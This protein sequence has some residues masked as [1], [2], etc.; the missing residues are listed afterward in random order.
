MLKPFGPDIWMADGT[1]VTGALGFLYPTRMAVIR[2]S[3]GALFVW[4]PTAP[5]DRLRGE[6]DK[7]GA[8]RHLIAP[9]SLHHL[10]IADWK[11][12]YPDAQL[13]AAPGLR[14]KRKDI[15]FDHDLGEMPAPDWAGQ[16]D[17]VVVAGNVITRETVF[18]H[19]ESGTALFTDLLQQLPAGWFSG[20]RG[21]IARW[22]LMVAA[23][24]S[25]PRKFRLA[26]TDRNAA[27]AAVDRILAW[28]SRKC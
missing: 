20:W 15:A 5:T 19:K 18:F 4:S 6:I 22:D 10:F 24:P 7:L 17:Q 9:N 21:F 1:T 26:F 3:D 27:R 23:E 13:H 2:L 8:V 28:Q 14:A 25:V 16:I 11:R 12:A